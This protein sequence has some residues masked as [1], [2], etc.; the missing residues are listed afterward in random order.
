MTDDH[1]TTFRVEFISGETVDMEF[2]NGAA[3]SLRELLPQATTMLGCPDCGNLVPV[4]GGIPKREMPR[5]AHCEDE[6]TGVTE[7]HELHQ[8]GETLI[9]QTATE[10]WRERAAQLCEHGVPEQRANVVALREQGRSYSEIAA[11]LEFG[12]DGRDRSQ[13]T[14]HIDS[15]REQLSNSE[16]LVQHAPD[17]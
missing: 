8:A 9:S 11:E 2:G 4:T 16:W 3:E 13:V 15:Y 14:Y 17:I 10:D 5:C 7:V 12:E 1:T 6:L